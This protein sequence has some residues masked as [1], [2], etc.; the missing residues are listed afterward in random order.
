MSGVSRQQINGHVLTP[1]G[2]VRG[3]LTIVDGRIAGI[4]GTPISE[5]QARVSAEPPS[6]PMSTSREAAPFFSWSSSTACSGVGA[7]GRKAERS[8]T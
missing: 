7:L 8:A 5:G 2:F 4:E 6:M 3:T 1:Q